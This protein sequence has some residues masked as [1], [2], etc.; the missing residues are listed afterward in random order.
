MLL[1]FTLVLACVTAV[2]SS[3]PVRHAVA[4]YLESPP[5]N[6]TMAVGHD[7]TEDP[8]NAATVLEWKPPLGN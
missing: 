8:A 6:V 1:Y 3:N 4:D 2:L 5:A 7:I